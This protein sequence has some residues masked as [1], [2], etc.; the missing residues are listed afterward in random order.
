MQSSTL[1]PAIFIFSLASCNTVKFIQHTP[2]LANTGQHTARNQLHGKLLYSSGNSTANSSDYY[3]SDN[4]SI[5]GLQAQASYSISNSLAIQSSFM[6]S[7]EKGASLRNSLT[8]RPK[9]IDYNYKRNITEGGLAYYK[10]LNAKKS[11]FI[12]L[13]GGA[14]SGSYKATEA[15]SV[16]VPGGRFYD[17]NVF[18]LYFQPSVYYASSNIVVS[19]GGKFSSI[20]FNNI[21]TNYT[22]QEREARSITTDN[23]LNISTFDFFMKADFYLAKL[24]WVGLNLQMQTTTDLQ[25][26]FYL[27]QNDFNVGIGLS[28]RLNPKGGKSKY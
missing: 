14:G 18:K 23:K 15:N 3:G 19:V 7:S 13:A 11:F 10:N 4:E 26:N 12:E 24:P 2:T 8:N 6:H 1:L 21:K 5:H 27:N 28:F 17:H 16:I 20:N 9:K 25:P 22:S